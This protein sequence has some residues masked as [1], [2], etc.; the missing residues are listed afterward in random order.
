MNRMNEI[1][2]EEEDTRA[3]GGGSRK[4]GFGENSSSKSSSSTIGFKTRVFRAYYWMSRDRNTSQTIGF[5][6]IIGLFA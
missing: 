2:S 3:K 6:L 5:L 1:Q 4:P